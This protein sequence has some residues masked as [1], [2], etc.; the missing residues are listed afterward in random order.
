MQYTSVDLERTRQNPAVV[1]QMP[2][3]IPFQSAVPAHKLHRS[4]QSIIATHTDVANGR[5]SR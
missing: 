1:L 4:P 5:K 3:E 2:V